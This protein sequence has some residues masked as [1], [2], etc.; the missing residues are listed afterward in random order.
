MTELQRRELF[1]ALMQGVPGVELLGASARRE[2]EQIVVDE[3]DRIEPLV[4]EMIT[5]SFG[6]GPRFSSRKTEQDIV[7]ATNSGP[8]CLSGRY[9]TQDPLQSLLAQAHKLRH[10]ISKTAKEGSL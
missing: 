2:M 1:D 5:K 4:D 6:A 3:I 8:V 10:R 9:D 7:D